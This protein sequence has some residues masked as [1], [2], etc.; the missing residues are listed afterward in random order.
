MNEQLRLSMLAKE[1]EKELNAIGLTNYNVAEYKVSNTQRCWGDCLRRYNGIVNS[2]ASYSFIVRVSRR[3]LVNGSDNDVKNT[4]IHELIHTM[5]NCFD[6]GYHF[7]RMAD[8]VNSAYSRY[9]ISRTN[10]CEGF[11]NSK[12][13]LDDK[14]SRAKYIFKCSCGATATFLR[15]NTCVNIIM[16]GYPNGQ[17]VRCR[18]CGHKNEFKVV[19]SR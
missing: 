15:R 12:A 7:K 14:V 16:S 9:H 2:K 10:G 4:L 13:L 6:H 18:A 11:E 5:P 19:K 8:K 17:W 1:A 3:L